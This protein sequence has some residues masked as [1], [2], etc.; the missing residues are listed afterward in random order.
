MKWWSN[1]GKDGRT[2]ISKSQF[3]CLDHSGG[4][5]LYSPSKL[6][7]IVVVRRITIEHSENPRCRIV[8]QQF[9]SVYLILIIPLV[10]W[11]LKQRSVWINAAI[12]ILF[13][14]NIPPCEFVFNLNVSFG[15]YGFLP[16]N[17]QKYTQLHGQIFHIQKHM[18]TNFTA[19]C[20]CFIPG[21]QI[22]I[23]TAREKIKNITYPTSALPMTA[24]II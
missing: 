21:V 22:E 1:D 11:A 4:V 19:I 6:C 24:S 13:S 8:V 5:T 17:E 16:L 15:C 2:S 7:H 3:R 20:L 14:V 18:E 10:N 23:E 12:S 9:M